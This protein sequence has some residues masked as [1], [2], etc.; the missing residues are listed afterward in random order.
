MSGQPLV[1]A[2]G[3]HS[4]VVDPTAFLA[5][6]SVVLGD[7]EIGPQASVWYGTVVRADSAPIRI[8]AGTNL[9][10]GVV[11]HADPLYPTTIG[12][13]VSVGHRAVVH[14]C[15]VGDDVLIGMGA[16]LL[17]GAVVGPWCLI[18]AGAVVL[19]G[20]EIPAG[21][22]VAGVPGKVRRTLSE[23]ERT[24][25]ALNAEAYLHATEAHRDVLPAASP[26]SGA[27]PASAR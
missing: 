23:E 9:Q 22:L 24:A 12:A 4:P 19:Q 11:V 6:G 7:V 8:G 25:I 13:R 5:A 1:A 3:G 18:A 15:T 21:S 16:T 27:A 17:N 10:D 2:V 20:A 26:A 14:G